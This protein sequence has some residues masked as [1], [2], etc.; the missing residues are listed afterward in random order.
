MSTKVLVTG[1]PGILA[2]RFVPRLLQDGIEVT[3][4]SL[5][6]WPDAPCPHVVSDLTDLGQAMEAVRGYDAVLHLAAV[7][8]EG[9]R[10]PATTFTVNV[11]S[12]FNILYGAHAAGVPR[13][14][15]AS[16]CHAGG[17]RWTTEH[18]P[19]SVP[20]SEAD[21]YQTGDTYGLSKRVGEL[22]T[23]QSRAWPGMSTCAIRY[24]YVHGI[25]QYDQIER[26]WDDP[27]YWAHSLWNYIDE[28]DAYD[29]TH[30]AL[31]MPYDG[32]HV[33]FATAADQSMNTPTRELVARYLPGT[34]VD[35]ALPE[36][37]SLISSDAAHA[38]LGFTAQHSWRDMLTGQR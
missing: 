6:P 34:T 10:T 15:S 20:I 24:G 27:E 28:R 3:T 26:R 37:G 13:V 30:R 4:T 29:L 5:L 35:P 22:L 16:S 38:L 12:T 9:I 21:D 23:L 33:L 17:G 7:H 25:D 31:T 18:V 2:N 14:V 1:A 19:T 11:A 32:G 8:R 36:Y